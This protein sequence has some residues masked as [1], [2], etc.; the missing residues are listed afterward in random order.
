MRRHTTELRLADFPTSNVTE[1]NVCSSEEVT[2]SSE[3]KLTESEL[4]NI[5]WDDSYDV[6]ATGSSAHNEGSQIGVLQ[7]MKLYPREAEMPK[8]GYQLSYELALD[9]MLTPFVR[10][11]A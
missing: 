1:K 4:L 7:E 9:N 3:D 8:H 2:S 10:G 11:Y 5:C 6:E